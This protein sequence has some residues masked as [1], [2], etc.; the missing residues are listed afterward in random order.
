M[1][2][3]YIYGEGVRMNAI[4]PG[5]FVGEQNRALLMRDDGTLTDRRRQVIEHTP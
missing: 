2:A 4:V 5:F 3:T 1:Y